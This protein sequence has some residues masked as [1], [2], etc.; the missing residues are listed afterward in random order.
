MTSARAKELLYDSETM[1]R[2]VD[3]ELAELRDEP[4]AADRLAQE[5]VDQ[6]DESIHHAATEAMARQRQT[7]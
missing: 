4:S 6:G 7:P 5:I 1:L 3:N 2:L